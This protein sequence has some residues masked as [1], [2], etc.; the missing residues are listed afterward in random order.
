MLDKSQVCWPNH[1]SGME[2]AFNSTINASIQKVPFKV[3]NVKNVS[4][5]I[6]MLLSRESS[7]KPQ[8][9]EFAGKMKQLFNKVKSTVH[10]S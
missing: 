7:F 1:L 6:D 5:P 10:N 2:L 3:I 8:A 9:N 4:L